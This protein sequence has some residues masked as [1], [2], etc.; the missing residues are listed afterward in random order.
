MEKPKYT[1]DDLP[2][3]KPKVPV[4]VY[5]FIKEHLALYD[6]V[7]ANPDMLD[8]QIKKNDPR[9]PYP[10][11]KYEVSYKV[12]SIVG[13]NGD[14][15]PVYGDLHRME[16]VIPNDYPLQSAACKMITKVWHPN[17]KYEGI[18]EGTICSSSPEFGTLFNLDELV[19]RIG[20]MLQY[21]RYHALFVEPWPEDAEVA[22]WVTNYAEV[23]GVA[24]KN[25]DPKIAVDSSPWKQYSETEE[26]GP[27]FPDI[28]FFEKDPTPPPPI[29]P[30][31][32]SDEITFL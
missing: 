30:E 18:G 21:R 8:I 7:R 27:A 24:N 26:E 16:I 5:R 32:D 31:Q 2:E 20:E 29:Q 15:S 22:K 19:V 12:K 9:V 11:R 14:Q 13:I 25:L 3:I 23:N 17:I 1:Y 10:P 4:D 6:L 28:D